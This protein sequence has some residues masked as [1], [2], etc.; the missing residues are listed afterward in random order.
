MFFYFWV[1]PACSIFFIA[2]SFFYVKNN[3]VHTPLV[4]WSYT[5]FRALPLLPI[6]SRMSKNPLFDAMLYD[7]LMFIICAIA[8]GLMSKKG[9]PAMTTMNV[10]GFALVC[11][12]F[13]LMQIK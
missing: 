4:F 13:V 1:V 2:L 3:E 10:G 5:I 7:I 8:I 12:G 6:I 11:I 9:F